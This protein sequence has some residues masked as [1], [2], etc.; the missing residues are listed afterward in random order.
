MSKL[1]INAFGLATGIF[2]VVWDLIFLSLI[3]ISPVTALNFISQLTLIKIAAIVT[4]VTWGSVLIFFI[5]GFLTGYI[6]GAVFAG[7]YNLA[8]GEYHLQN[9]NLADKTNDSSDLSGEIQSKV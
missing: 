2:F 5:A 7:I 4:T 1:N 9:N 6:A 8:A 3:I